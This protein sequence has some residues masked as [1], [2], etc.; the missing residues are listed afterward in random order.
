MHK[1][2][3]FGGDIFRPSQK[4]W[5]CQNFV[6]Y[7]FEMTEIFFPLQ[8]N[9][10]FRINW[11]LGRMASITGRKWVIFVHPFPL[12]PQKY[13][14]CNHG[15]L[16]LSEK[17]IS[18]FSKKLV[19]IAKTALHAPSFL[20]PLSRKPGF[21]KTSGGISLSFDAMIRGWVVNRD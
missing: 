9:D 1:Q 10:R 7:S 5:K 14:L 8:S 18:K 15:Q 2:F 17:H 3:W 20:P 19:L 16:Y 21:I 13:G 12:L 4:S 6:L 11:C